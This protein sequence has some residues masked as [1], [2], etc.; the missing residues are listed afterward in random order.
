M[1]KFHL[2]LFLSLIATLI[3]PMSSNVFSMGTY[4]DGWAIVQILKFQKEGY[5]F[6]S[7][8]GVLRVA[9]YDEDEECDEEDFKCYT[10]IAE[11]LE[12]SVDYENKD[13]ARFIN[14]NIGTEMLVHYKKHRIAPTGLGTDFEV[15]EAIP[16]EDKP[17]KTLPFRY[18]VEKSGSKRTFAFFGKILRME[19]RGTISSYE[20]LYY[21]IEKDTVHPFTIDD[22]EFAEYVFQAMKYRKE[23]FLGVNQSRFTWWNDSNYNLFELNFRNKP[24]VI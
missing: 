9:T 8:E 19:R 4:A 14:A 1:G 12:F 16:R 20:G 17:P 6:E 7:F 3:G 13:L 21:N 10:P 24:E 18:E 22:D 2:S 5:S 15:L 11:D 23:Y